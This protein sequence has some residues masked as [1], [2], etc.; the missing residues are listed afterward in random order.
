MTS[1]VELELAAAAAAAAAGGGAPRL[2]PP[3][4]AGG[5]PAATDNGAAAAAALAAAHERIEQ[6]LDDKA[7]L[8]YEVEV[9]DKKVE[10]LREE[11]C[12]FIYSWHSLKRTDCAVWCRL[13]PRIP[14]LPSPRPVHKA[15]FSPRPCCY[16]P[17][18]PP[19]LLCAAD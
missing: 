18:S 15:H 12:I 4:D 2:L 16:C 1:E 14:P 19:H 7:D 13:L 9:V 6:L 11:V 8:E 17:M 5:A 3:E 10:L